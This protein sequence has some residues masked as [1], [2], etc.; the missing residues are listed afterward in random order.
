VGFLHRGKTGKRQ[1]ERTFLYGEETP[2]DGASDKED[3]ERIRQRME[4]DRHQELF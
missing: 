3:A 4:F 2:N 1:I